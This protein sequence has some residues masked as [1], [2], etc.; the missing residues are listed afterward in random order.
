[1][2]MSVLVLGDDM[3]LVTESPEPGDQKNANKN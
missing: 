3:G 1:M 2:L